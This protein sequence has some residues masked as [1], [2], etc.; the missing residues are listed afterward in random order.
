MLHVMKD[1][2]LGQ[3]Y[4]EK[5]FPLLSL[6]EY[7]EITAEQLRYLPSDIVIHRL[8]GDARSIYLLRPN[9]PKEICG[10][11]RNRQ[12]HAKKKYLARRQGEMQR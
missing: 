6:E 7:V 1:T 12:I 3:M 9:G 2:P 10:S 5:P 11:E 8:T 4:L